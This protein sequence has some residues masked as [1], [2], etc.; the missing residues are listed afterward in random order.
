MKTLSGLLVFFLLQGCSQSYKPQFSKAFDYG[1]IYGE[2]NRSEPDFD[3]ILNQNPNLTPEEDEM[4][5]EMQKSTAGMV[6]LGKHVK[7][8][9]DG[10]IS[11]AKELLTLGDR[12][13]LCAGEKFIDQ[14]TLPVCSG[15]LVG[16]DLL[17]TAGHC[18]SRD[19]FK[20][21]IW[22]F[23]YNQEYAHDAEPVFSREFVY[24]T[25]EVVLWEKDALTKKDFAVVRLDR[26]VLG[27]K[28]LKIRNSGK[29]E[30]GDQLAIIGHPSGLPSK[31]S[32]GAKVLDASHEN[33]IKTN[34]DSFGGNSGSVVINIK[35]G[36][37]EGIL[38]SG[39]PDYIYSDDPQNECQLVNKRKEDE[40]EEYITRISLIASV[41][42]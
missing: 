9:P 3:E 28:A 27:V 6:E 10:S 36:K 22:I 17:V 5:L 23:G 33:S 32:A 41:V 42:N 12:K 15:F 31:I 25:K 39:A 4:L 2:D 14:Y 1:V 37:V 40:G 38:V 7:K 11:P 29:L 13:N 26:K 24:F 8:N 21:R 30:D 19:D 18:L 35:T 34:L 16:P 20:N